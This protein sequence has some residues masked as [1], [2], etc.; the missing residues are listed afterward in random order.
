MKYFESFKYEISP[1]KYRIESLESSL[2]KQVHYFEF[3]ALKSKSRID[4][5]K[6][7]VIIPHIKSISSLEKQIKGF[8]FDFFIICFALCHTCLIFKKKVLLNE[9]G[10]NLPIHLATCSFF[11]LIGGSWFGFNYAKSISL[12]KSHSNGLKKMNKLNK[13]FDYYYTTRHEEVFEE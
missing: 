6:T 10:N 11:G 1:L 8:S 12:Y 7:N 5:F 13:D 4:D 9:M 3:S 2:R